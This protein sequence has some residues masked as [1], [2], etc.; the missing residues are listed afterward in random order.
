L[1][2]PLAMFAGALPA[3]VV[4]KPGFHIRA[5]CECRSGDGAALQPIHRGKTAS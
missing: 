1:I 4:I 2:L 5:I 3:Q